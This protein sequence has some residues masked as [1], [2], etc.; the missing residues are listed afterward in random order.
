MAPAK[1]G[2]HRLELSHPHV[3]T[4]LSVLQPQA[5]GSRGEEGRK[6][7]D[8]FDASKE[9]IMGPYVTEPGSEWEYG[10]G[11]DWAVSVVEKISGLSLND[12]FQRT[13][14]SPRRQACASFLPKQAGLTDKLVGSPPPR[15]GGDHLGQRPLD[16]AGRIQDRGAVRW[17]WT[18]ANAAEYCQVLVAL[19]N[20]GTHPKTGGKIPFGLERRR[21]RQGAAHRQASEDMDREF[22]NTDP[23]H[24]QLLRGMYRQGR[25]QDVGAGRTEAAHRASDVQV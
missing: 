22:P 18:V 10:V 9:S 8:A 4:R 25:P 3:R 2:A 12:Y 5:Q 1:E 7:F 11:M 23:N 21:A 14:S 6:V 24:H 17:R 16:A 19:L 20:G 13:S 15:P